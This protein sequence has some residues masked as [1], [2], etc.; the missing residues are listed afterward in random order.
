[1]GNSA[2]V[3]AIPLRRGTA[4]PHEQ[5]WEF[6]FYFVNSGW[7]RGTSK[8]SVSGAISV[9]GCRTLPRKKKILSKIP[10]ILDIT[11]RC[12]LGG[13]GRVAWLEGGREVFCFS[14]EDMII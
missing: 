5:D 4:M 13:L 11:R 12:A 6:N 10:L 3:Q 9:S 8:I 1:M 7:L 14:S 2:W